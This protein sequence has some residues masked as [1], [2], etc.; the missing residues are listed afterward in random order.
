MSKE[1]IILVGGGGH[2]RSVI[3]V[4]ET[5]N[6]YEIVGILDKPEL[7]GQTFLHDYSIR[8]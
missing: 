5:E 4:I 6:R 2:C 1:K 3:D 8:Q 7:V